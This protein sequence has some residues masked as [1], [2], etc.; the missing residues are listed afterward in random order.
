MSFQLQVRG[1]K[2][3][4]MCFF[5]LRVEFKTS[6]QSVRESTELPHKFQLH[7]ATVC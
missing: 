7:D 1:Y 4:K 2:L 5:F 6:P 3:T